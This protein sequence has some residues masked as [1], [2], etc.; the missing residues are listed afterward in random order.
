M[1]MCSIC[2]ENFTLT[3]SN[4]WGMRATYFL[5]IVSFPAGSSLRPYGFH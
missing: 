1:R 3:I 2:D 4:S 5:I